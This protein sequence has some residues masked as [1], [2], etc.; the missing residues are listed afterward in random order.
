MSR[1]DHL[2]AVY[3]LLSLEAVLYR[4]PRARLAELLGPMPGGTVVDIGCGTGLNL[5]WL[6]AAVTSSGRVVG[7]DN[8]TSMLAA[9]RR[10]VRRHGWA[11]VT[12]LHADIVELGQVLTARSIE[13]DALVATFVLSV[14]ADDSGFWSVVDEVA[15]TRP[16]RV[17]L[18]ELGAASGAPR[19]LRWALDALTILGGGRRNRRPWTRLLER[20]DDSARL[21][22]LGGHVQVAAGCVSARRS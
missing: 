21:Q 11:N 2:G 6:C 17:G 13:P 15:V 4:R 7:V 19:P 3:D 1:Y 10:R 9:A 8:S 22:F 14:V 16:L 18:A 12:L 5:A 20:A